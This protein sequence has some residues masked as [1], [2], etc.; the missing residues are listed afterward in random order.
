MTK[1]G[2]VCPSDGAAFYPAAGWGIQ[3]H[4]LCVAPTKHTS[5][6]TVK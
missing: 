5:L 2:N 4:S 3:G 1:M 6:I